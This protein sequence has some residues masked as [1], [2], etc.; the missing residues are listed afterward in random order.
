MVP[1]MTGL[2]PGD[3][4]LTVFLPALGALVL[5]LIPRDMTQ[6]LFTTAL[7]TAMLTFLWSLRILW[8]FIPAQGEMQFTERL[9]WIPAYGIDYLIG[10][11]GLSLFLVLLATFL[12][13]IVILASWSIT[14]RVKE[15][16][17][18]MLIL[19]TGMIGTLVA[20]D[21][22]LFYVF[23]ELMLVPMYFIIGTSMSAFLGSRPMVSTTSS[24][25]MGLA[26]SWSCSP[27]FSDPLS[28]SPRGA[29]PQGSKN[30]SFSC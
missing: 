25:S 5:L 2:L 13:P 22:F 11:D 14:A 24:G 8:R 16:L 1:L 30:I 27:P 4:S 21:L 19:E 6:A 28:S 12:G 3:L 26:F 15:Y 18:F 23:W 17:F 10:I 20:L 7:A 9:S 29:L